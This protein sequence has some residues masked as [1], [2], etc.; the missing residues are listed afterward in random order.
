MHKLAKESYKELVCFR[1][2]CYCANSQREWCLDISTF[3]PGHNA[4]ES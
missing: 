1:S 2:C 4:N 3:N